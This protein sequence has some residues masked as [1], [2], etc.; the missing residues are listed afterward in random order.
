ME[1]LPNLSNLPSALSPPEAVPTGVNAD[2][3]PDAQELL[4]F[5]GVRFT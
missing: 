2:G 5:H 4:K 1:Q 3:T